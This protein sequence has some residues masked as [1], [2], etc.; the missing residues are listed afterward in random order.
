MVTEIRLYIE[1]DSGKHRHPTLREGF[2]DFLTDIVGIARQKKVGFRLIMAGSRQQ[3]CHDFI[4]A[5]RIY[6]GNGVYIA[7]L[8]DSEGPL[9]GREPVDL[10]SNDCCPYR[11]VAQPE[12]CHL[13][14]EC[15]ESWFLAD[16]LALQRYYGKKFNTGTWDQFAG[17][18]YYGDRLLHGDARFNC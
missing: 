17:P 3:A 7:L 10:L 13:M 2:R 1:G 9:A 16:V 8:V 14:V 18:I 4:T 15:M 5:L 6:R 11:I 12:Q